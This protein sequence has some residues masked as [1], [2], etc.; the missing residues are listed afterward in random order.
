MSVYLHHMNV[1]TIEWVF[2]APYECLH[3]WMSVFLHHMNVYTIEWVFFAP[4]ECLHNWMSICTVP[5]STIAWIYISTVWIFAQLNE[6]N[7]TV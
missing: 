3:N 4:Y 2:F 6:S 5:V 1:Y 7:C